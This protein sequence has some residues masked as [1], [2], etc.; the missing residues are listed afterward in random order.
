MKNLLI[1]GSESGIGK[2]MS[3]ILTT[4]GHQ[5]FGVSRNPQAEDRS[6]VSM[7]FEADAVNGDLEFFQSLPSE[8]HGLAYCPGS[9][10][11]RPFTRLSEQDIF[12]DFRQNV[13]GAVRII[14][15]AIPHLK[16][17]GG[18]GV[19]LFSTVAVG[20]GMP[21]HASVAA[22]KGAVEGLTRSLAAEYASAGLRFNAIAPSLTDTPLAAGLLNTPQ[23][24]ESAAARHPL[25]RIGQH[26]DAAA[27]AAF[28]LSDEGSWITGQVIGV[29]GGIG[30]LRS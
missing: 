26:S 19:V 21:F 15:K 18:A 10:N 29:D 1:I 16:Q 13:W 9:I 4:Q 6:A 3:E 27:L 8:L 24:R 28:L 22:S 5:V 14:Q 30:S 23:K 20:T 17:S 7:H 2:R 12:S 25:G 11:L